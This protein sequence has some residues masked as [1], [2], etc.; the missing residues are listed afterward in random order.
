MRTSP[1]SNTSR[2]PTSVWMAV[3]DAV[4]RPDRSAEEAA[5][6]EVR[7]GGTDD[8]FAPLVHV[9]G[10]VWLIEPQ[11]ERDGMPP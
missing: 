8:D 1:R 11:L 6:Q 9:V 4:N 2:I 5:H 3:D 10:V 7:R